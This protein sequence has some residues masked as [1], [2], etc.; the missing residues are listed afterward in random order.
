MFR[1][2]L[3]RHHQGEVMFFI[4]ENARD[5]ILQKYHFY[6]ENFVSRRHQNNELILNMNINTFFSLK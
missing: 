2:Y 4:Y 3:L 5:K 6:V 1:C